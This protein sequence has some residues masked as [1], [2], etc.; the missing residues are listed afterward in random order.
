M[1]LRNADKQKERTAMQ[2]LGGFVRIVLV[3]FVLMSLIS[4]HRS[5]QADEY[6]ASFGKTSGDPSLVLQELHKYR[7]MYNLTA[8]FY[9]NVGLDPA[10]FLLSLP[11][12]G[13]ID[14]CLTCFGQN[15]PFP[16]CKLIPELSAGN[17]YSV[18]WEGQLWLPVSGAYT[19]NLSNVDDG[20]RLFIDGA[21]VVD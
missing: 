20:V 13:T 14:F 12:T 1:V 17:Y 21:E 19:F 18:R 5:V 8:S 4:Y 7:G 6:L 11:Y 2:K 15:P 10:S 16:S 3:A 9:D